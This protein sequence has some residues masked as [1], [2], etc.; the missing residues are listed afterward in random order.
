M[1]NEKEKC[2]ECERRRVA[3][4]IAKAL[5]VSEDGG[6]TLNIDLRGSTKIETDAVVAKRLASMLARDMRDR[7]DIG[8]EAAEL[9][10]TI[11]GGSPG[12]A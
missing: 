12:R 8:V 4:A 10:N 6:V 11:T 5:T 7:K 1:I 2:E 9:E 3:E